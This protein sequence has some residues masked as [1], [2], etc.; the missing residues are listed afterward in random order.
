MQTINRLLKLTKKNNTS[1]GFTLLELIIASTFSVLV[2]GAAG[3]GLMN[4]LRGNQKTNVQVDRRTEVNRGIEFISDEIRK[5]ETIELDPT[6]AFSDAN[7]SD[8]NAQPILAL[9]IPGV[10]NDPDGDGVRDPFP[11]IYYLSSPKS[12]EVW[13]G[14]VLYR[15]GPPIDSTGNYTTANWQQEALIDNLS[16][17]A[18]TPNCD[19][20]WTQSPS[21]NVKGFYACIDSDQKTAE[22]FAFSKIEISKSPAKYETY[23][24][25]TKTY[26]RADRNP[27]D[28]SL[29]P[30][31]Y[32]CTITSGAINCGSGG[33]DLLITKV[34][35]GFGC[36]SN[37]N[38]WTTDTL[39]YVQGESSP[40]TLS[41]SAPAGTTAPAIP[42]SSGNTNFSVVAK[43]DKNSCSTGNF[44]EQGLQNNDPVID[45]HDGGSWM[46]NLTD[47]PKF[48]PWA[49]RLLKDGDTLP[50]LDNWGEDHPNHKKLQN[51]L[52]AYTR[53]DGSKIV[54]NGVITLKKNEYL[55]SFEIGQIDEII[56]KAPPFNPDTNPDTDD[57]EDYLTN[58]PTPETATEITNLGLPPGAD[59]QDLVLLIT[60]PE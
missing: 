3:Y 44:A 60:L 7:I 27:L 9:N 56:A 35:D 15:H 19:S 59:W 1:A 34:G 53:P 31:D 4:M 37:K 21:S 23:E 45:N 13:Q 22:I 36:D 10:D 11:V 20:G 2:I 25:S 49:S 55:L 47:P 42:L 48:H 12:G 33:G 38:T 6:Q 32:T 54:D 14:K 18:L 58:N 40:T 5:A 28:P 41:G 26:A 39:I 30:A 16:D 29:N 50:G 17:A 46:P 57:A 51:Q 8:S 52:E 43:A 24:A